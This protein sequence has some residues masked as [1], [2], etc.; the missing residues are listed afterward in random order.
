MPLTKTHFEAIAAIVKRATTFTDSG[1]FVQG[2]NA[3][4]R[5][6]ASE[7]AVYFATQNPQFSRERFLA[8]CGVEAG[9]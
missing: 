4:C 9:K 6:M 3:A 2:R 8:A 1:E 5:E 7:L